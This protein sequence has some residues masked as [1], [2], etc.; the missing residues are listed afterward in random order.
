MKSNKMQIKPIHEVLKEVE[1][2]FALNH[3]W[4]GSGENFSDF[5]GGGFKLSVNGL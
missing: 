4:I 5:N 1:K 3:N 2:D